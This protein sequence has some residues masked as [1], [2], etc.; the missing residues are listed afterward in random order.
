MDVDIRG[1]LQFAASS[2]TMKFVVVSWWYRR[3]T[4][5]VVSVPL[6]NHACYNI[7]ILIKLLTFLFNVYKR[8]FISVTFLNV[9]NRFL[10]FNM[11]VFLP[12]RRIGGPT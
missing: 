9:F 3:G 12:A 4:E 10:N 8:F 11:N 5:T 6:R 2:R 7:E 1:K